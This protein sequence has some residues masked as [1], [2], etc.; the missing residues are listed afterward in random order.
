MAKH[1]KPIRRY[2]VS[3]LHGE[4]WAYPA[5]PRYAMGNSA[6]F[7]THAEA[8]TYAHQMAGS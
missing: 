6:T 3:K 2:W 8:I 1:R 4:W 5:D 7:A